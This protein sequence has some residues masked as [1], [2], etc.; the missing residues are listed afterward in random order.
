MQKS[1]KLYSR[2]LILLRI[3][4]INV[5][6]KLSNR[7][8]DMQTHTHTHLH[9]KA[10]W[11][12]KGSTISAMCS[13]T[14]SEKQADNWD[15]WNYLLIYC[16]TLIS[17]HIRQWICDW[18]K[19]GF[20]KATLMSECE[21]LQCVLLHAELLSAELG[22][23]TWKWKTEIL[24]LTFTWSNKLFFSPVCNKIQQ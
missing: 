15:T 4:L 13:P 6:I 22:Y 10:Q 12:I 8:M 21:Y 5:R 18:F 23:I 16:S 7:R 11:Y 19:W 3:I 20:L 9:T 2:T 24:W 17:L 14:A 1:S